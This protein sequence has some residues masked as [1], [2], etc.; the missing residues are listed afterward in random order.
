MGLFPRGGAV[1]ALEG[2]PPDQRLDSVHEVLV[3]VLHAELEA[4]G[5]QDDAL[6]EEDALLEA[7]ALLGLW[8]ELNEPHR[9]G[10]RRGQGASDC[11]RCAC[12]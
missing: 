9:N 5:V 4:D 8:V 2:P 3:R 12:S 6:E 11:P 7:D 10:G 1:R